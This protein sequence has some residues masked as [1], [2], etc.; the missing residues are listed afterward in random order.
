MGCE[1]LCP[2]YFLAPPMLE[3]RARI[4]TENS[5]RGSYKGAIVQKEVGS[6]DRNEGTRGRARRIFLAE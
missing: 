3:E 2:Q 1:T 6:V 4:Q 5:E